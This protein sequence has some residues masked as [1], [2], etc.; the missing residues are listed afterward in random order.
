[1]LWHDIRKPRGDGLE[2][3]DPLGIG[4]GRRY[5][6]QIETLEKGNFFSS[7]DRTGIAPLTV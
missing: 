3:K 7:I 5:A 2:Q 6:K 4:I 1:M